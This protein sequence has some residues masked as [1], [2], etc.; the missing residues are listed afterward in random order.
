[1]RKTFQ[2]YLF[3]M[4]EYFATLFVWRLRRRVFAV[5][6]VVVALAGMFLFSNKG[7][8]RRW[9]LA[10]EKK[11]LEQQ[12]KELQHQEDSLRTLRDKLQTDPFTIE[13]TAR[14]QYG[15]T[16]PGETVYRRA[17]KQEKK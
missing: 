10:G 17:P 5:I 13:Q 1:M 12:L 8:L 3:A 15:L 9:Q 4:H 14:E 11:A 2:D 7:L 16:K 6:V